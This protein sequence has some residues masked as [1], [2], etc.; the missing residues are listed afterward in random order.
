MQIKI[1]IEVWMLS[2]TSEAIK[3]DFLC[4]T[5]SKLM[6]GSALY[7]GTRSCVI[8]IDT[9]VMKKLAIINRAPTKTLCSSLG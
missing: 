5:K 1:V 7:R 9:V 2:R 8:E 3:A 6:S 4:R